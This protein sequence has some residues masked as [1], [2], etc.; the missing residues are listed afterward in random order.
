M[1]K[2]LLFAL[3]IGTRNVVGLVGKR[4]GDLIDILAV[5]R[6]EHNTRSMLD[7][8][9]HDVPEV[10]KVIASV[11][12]HLEASVGPL[13]KVSVA[14]AGRALFTIQ[15]TAEIEILP[16]KLLTV[17][18][19]R[20]LELS[21]IQ[22]AQ[23]QLA[24]TKSLADPGSYYCVGY[25]I[26]NF[27]LD[28]TP[29]K[30][31]EGQ[32]GKIAGIEL[33]ATFLPRQVIDSLQSA[34]ESI[35]LE[36]STLTLEPIAAISVLIPSSMRHLNLTL[37][38][39]GAGT[40]D[41][42]ITRAGSVVGYGMVPCAGDE[43]TEA[44]STNFLLDFNMAETVKRRL[45]DSK[46]RKIP[47][48]DVLGIKH[49]AAPQEIIDSIKPA[50]KELAQTIADQILALNVTP[51]Q[52][53]LLVGGGSL[54]P[55]LPQLLAESLGIPPA[56]VGIRMP[57]QSAGMVKLP[58]ELCVPD[59]VTPL[60]ILKLADSRALT[61]VKVT[62]ND[63]LLRL[64]N[65]G[66][67]TIG[68][69]LLTA[70]IDVRSLHGRPGLGITVSINGQTNFIP[71]SN[72]EPGSILKNGAP[73]KLTDLL[74][75]QDII[76]VT[77][78]ANGTTPQPPLS[79]VAKIPSSYSVMIN[80]QTY[81][82]QPEI[83]NNDSAISA[84]TP[85]QDRDRIMIHLPVALQDVMQTLGLSPALTRYSYTVNGQPRLYSVA[86]Q[87]TVNDLPANPATI[88]HDKDIVTIIPPVLP[89][90]SSVLGIAEEDIESI[91]I[92]FNDAEIQ[93]PAQRYTISANK[94][95]A[96]LTDA[97]PDGTA[98]EYSCH[99]QSNPTIGEVLLAVDF[100]PRQ[101][102]GT[103]QITILHN[104]QPADFTTPIKNRDLIQIV[105]STDPATPEGT[106]A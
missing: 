100:D 81:A 105:F 63:Q 67:L 33:I 17:D 79:A 53:V 38:D 2:N 77:R 42:A 30:T 97:A 8:Q 96:K 88:L 36:M 70:G 72:P 65:L 12:K 98:I 58:N 28:K 66:A 19:E 41:V 91:T 34:L 85:L 50:V 61:F 56:R 83:T 48:T 95:P 25:S 80:G 45:G 44:I 64:F 101:L 1:E 89:T 27:S 32:R 7:G 39:I 10:A 4:V 93:I 24:A 43:I 102:S 99:D 62:V 31:L 54:T 23:R 51:P 5:H 35:G 21:A 37:V 76:Q 103:K 86:S 87:F 71:G 40:S 3:D 46:A 82:V 68:D 11:K 69:A 75:E 26:V 18:D 78:G 13:K 49:K 16:S 73:A 20:T 57:D 15:T 55:L 94:Q 84:D 14:A 106:P 60:G 90:I 59:A 104:R 9:I 6:Q 29:L 22:N 74:Q 52:A 47:Y 92:L